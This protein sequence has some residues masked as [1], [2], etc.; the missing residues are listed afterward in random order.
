MEEV[1]VIGFSKELFEKERA[2][3]TIDRYQQQPRTFAQWLGRKSGNKGNNGM[4][5]TMVD[6]TVFTG[7][8][9]CGI[10]SAKRL[11]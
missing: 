3:E 9:E 10:S 5:Q 4:L 6:E 1:A 11:F 7:Q 2:K 8:C